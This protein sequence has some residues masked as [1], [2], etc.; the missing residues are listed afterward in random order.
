MVQRHCIAQIPYTCPKILSLMIERLTHSTV[1]VE[2]ACF[3][4]RDHGPEVSL[5]FYVKKSILIWPALF[6]WEVEISHL[7][8]LNLLLMI[9]SVF[10]CNIATAKCVKN[11]QIAF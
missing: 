6:F 11:S 1:K 5:A 4:Q 2:K 9:L 10:N 7:M 3:R 8:L